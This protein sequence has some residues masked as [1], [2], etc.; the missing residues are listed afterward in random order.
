MDEKLIINE[1]QAKK[2][3]DFITIASIQATAY[4]LREQLVEYSFLKITPEQ[5]KRLGNIYDDFHKLFIEI[6]IDYNK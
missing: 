3:I 6:T 1:E 4:S 5:S 2:D